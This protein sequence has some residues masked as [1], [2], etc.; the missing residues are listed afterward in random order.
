MSHQQIDRETQDAKITQVRQELG[1]IAALDSPTA[2]MRALDLLASSLTLTNTDATDYDRLTLGA[3][4]VAARMRLR[5]AEDPLVRAL[6]D[7]LQQ[8]GVMLDTITR[9]RGQS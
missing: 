7:R 3:L 9:T 5:R 6:H 4:C 8:V 1:R 2:R